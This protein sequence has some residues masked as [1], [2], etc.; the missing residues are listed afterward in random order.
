MKSE[1]P[2]T[3]TEL[4]VRALRYLAQREHSRAELSRKLEAY[5]Q[6]PEALEALLAEL[7][8]KR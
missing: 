6:S 2:D 7:E 3:P 5:A 1:A 4:K 8:Q